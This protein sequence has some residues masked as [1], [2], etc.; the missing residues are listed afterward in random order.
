MKQ[1]LV[2]LR[3]GK[4]MNMKH[5]QIWAGTLIAALLCGLSSLA[6]SAV[7]PLEQAAYMTA[8]ASR[9][10]MLGVAQSKTRLIEVGEHGVI[11]YSDNQGAT[12]VQARVPVSVTLTA[13]TCTSEGTIWAVGHDGAVISSSDNG[14]SWT[15]RLDGNQ[16]NSLMQLQAKRRA[17]LAHKALDAANP[18]NKAVAQRES[19][20]SDNALADIEAAAKFGPS[21]PLLGVWFKNENDGLVIGSYGQIFHTSDGGRNWESYATRLKNKDGL[22]Y[23]GIS[24]TRAGNVLIAGEGG[25]VYRST[26]GGA[27]W[28]ALNTG[29]QGQLYGALGAVDGKGNEML[30]AFGF[31]GHV[32]HSTAGSDH[33]SEM[34]SATQKNLVAGMILPD[35][36]VELV[37][38]DGSVIRSDRDLTVFHQ[39]L[40]GSGLALAGA[41]QITSGRKLIAVGTGGAH[42]LDPAEDNA[43]GNVSHTGKIQP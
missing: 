40:P 15:R 9:A 43:D 37:G 6:Y 11:N 19:D 25:Q 17:E 20:E 12:W 35:G 31:G 4:S 22:H 3:R 1:H 8:K 34:A 24:A 21:R 29:Y 30:I 14:V 39:V 28:Q 36:T 23:N 2:Q 13:V 18:A 16:A 42:T 27:N 26:D 33:W 32:F 5:N 10:M 38:Q 7:D 41:T